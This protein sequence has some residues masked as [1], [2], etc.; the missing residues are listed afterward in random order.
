MAHTHDHPGHAAHRTAGPQ[1]GDAAPVLVEVTRGP[2]VESRHR[3]IAVVADR[4]GRV[5]L[6]AGDFERPVFPRSAIKP[7]QAIPLVESGAVERF[8]LG[9]AEIALACASHSGESAH[10][11]TVA[12]W[13]ARIGCTAADLECG[14]QAP[15]DAQTAAALARSGRT[16]GALHNNCSGKHAGFLTT[17]R[18]RGEPT[19][20]YRELTHPVQQRVLGVL[21]QMTGQ[22][23]GAA[24]RALDGC[25]IPTIAVSLGGL[26]VAM[27][28][29][30]D[31]VDLPERRAAAVARIRAA[32]A[33]QPRLIGGRDR[34]DT[35][36]ISATGGRALTKGGAEGVHC[37]CLPELGLGVALKIEDGAKRAAEVAMAAVLDRLGLL[38]GLAPARAAR[39]TRSPVRTWRGLDAGEIRPAEGFPP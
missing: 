17:A 24:P 37:A 11:D 5:V 1:S 6:H 2:L 33:G 35:D 32:W 22:D 31:P 19:A 8:G 34:F 12:A 29:F 9:D 25:S 20:G 10:T 14:A 28:R 30:A 16:P 27:A 23:L 39:F 13:L 7:I 3:G 18:A 15:L 21:E 38:D 36:M 4:D 26:A